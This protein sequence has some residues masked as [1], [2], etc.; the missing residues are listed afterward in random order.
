M[1]RRPVSFNDRLREASVWIAAHTSEVVTIEID[2]DD[3]AAALWEASH[4]CRWP[5]ELNRLARDLAKNTRGMCSP[6]M[7]AGEPA[8]WWA[9]RVDWTQPG[10][11]RHQPTHDD[12]NDDACT[13]PCRLQREDTW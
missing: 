7:Q 10:A 2:R 5:S 9:D 3:L 1:G 6:C 4:D 12:C 8:D 13:C 11:P